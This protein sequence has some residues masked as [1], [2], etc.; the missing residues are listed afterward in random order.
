MIVPTDGDFDD[1]PPRGNKTLKK[2]VDLLRF[3]MLDLRNITK[4]SDRGGKW[5]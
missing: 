3:P 1:L 2:Q 4:N 5:L